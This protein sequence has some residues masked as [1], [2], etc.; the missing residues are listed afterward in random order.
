MIVSSKI[1]LQMSHFKKR[2]KKMYSVY[3]KFCASFCSCCKIPLN[4]HVF[5]TFSRLPESFCCLHEIVLRLY[6]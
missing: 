3:L 2:K 6:F 4:K 1:A 5:S